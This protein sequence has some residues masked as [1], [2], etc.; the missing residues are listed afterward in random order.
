M[1]ELRR[2][3]GSV[4]VKRTAD[5]LEYL[6]LYSIQWGREYGSANQGLFFEETNSFKLKEKDYSSGFYA[7][8][9]LGVE[10]ASVAKIMRHAFCCT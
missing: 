10:E 6:N 4:R 7:E 9:G 5:N 3:I 2:R 1:A 8:V